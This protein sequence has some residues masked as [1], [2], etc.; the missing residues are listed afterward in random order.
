MQSAERGSPGGWRSLGRA[1]RVRCQEGDA[2]TPALPSVSEPCG[3]AVP[4][5]NDV[6]GEGSGP[7]LLEECHADSGLGCPWVALVTLTVHTPESTA[8]TLRLDG[9]CFL[10]LFLVGHWDRCSV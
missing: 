10:C 6:G 3:G 5:S 7:A 9:P 2:Q 4:L 8:V 1:G